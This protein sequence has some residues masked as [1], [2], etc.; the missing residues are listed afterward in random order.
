MNNVFK[1][2]LIL[3]LISF[4]SYSQSNI[5]HEPERIFE[6]LVEKRTKKEFISNY[7]IKKVSF[8]RDTILS[9]SIEYDRE[10]N[11]FETI[12]ME[13]KSVRKTVYKWDDKNRLIEKK[14]FNSDGSFRYGYYYLY[15]NGSK[16]EYEIKDSLL[17]EKTSFLKEE[18][19]DTYIRFDKDGT[20]SS[21]FITIY[22]NEMRY[23][24]TSRYNKDN[25]YAQHR[26]EY[27]NNKKFIT[28]IKFDS[29]GTKINEKR[30]LTEIRTEN[31]LEHYAGDTEHLFRVD[32]YNEN[33]DMSEMIILDKLGD[34][35][36]IHSYY[37]DSKG[38]LS[39]LIKENFMRDTKTVYTYHYD[40]EGKIELVIKDYN[41]V[42]EVF[43]YRYDFF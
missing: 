2:S 21:K 41:G 36:N 24:M 31:G 39:E 16:F 37:Y 1:L 17:F 14:H 26:Y 43:R 20:V 22:D 28:R 4:A 40:L 32:T 18:K 5:Q 34:T 19:V 33:G 38:R 30:Y 42:I 7:G 35:N 9:S 11:L 3:V 8:Y 12:G 23:L 25:I 13:N 29:N 10:G 6:K 27:L 15:R